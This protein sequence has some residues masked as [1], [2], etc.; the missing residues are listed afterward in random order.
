MLPF[1]VCDLEHSR[2]RRAV[3]LPHLGVELGYLAQHVVIIR[4]R[5]IAPVIHDQ[6]Q[7]CPVLLGGQPLRV[8][9]IIADVERKPS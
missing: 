9:E 3:L 2:E 7:V 8:A 6:Q 5:A 4:R 1:T